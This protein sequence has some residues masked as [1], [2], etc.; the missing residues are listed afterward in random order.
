VKTAT[1]AR[2]TK[3]IEVDGR[4]LVISNEN[5]VLWPE[6]GYTKGDLIAYY[7][8]VARW[9][10]PHLENR[11]LTV[12]RYP[13][14]IHES[15]FFEKNAP[16]GLPDWIPTV[17]VPSDSGRR[18][19][20]HF[21]MCN[22]EPSLVYFGN[23]AAIV[24]HIWTSRAGSLEIPDFLFFDLDPGDGC[25]LATLAKVALELRATLGEIGLKP[26]IKTSGGSGLHVLVPLVPEYTYAI[27]KGFAEMI[28][29]TLNGRMPDE[30]TLARMPA[31][32]P[33]GTVYLDYVQVGMGKTLT[34]PY[35]VRARA[36]APVSFPLEW[37]EIES[38]SR[39]RAKDTEPE[40]AR[41]TIANV[42][43][44]LKKNGDLWAGAGWKEQR[45]EP[46]LAK[47]QKLWR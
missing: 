22:D 32:R 47:A 17:P 20:I 1:P 2:T 3:T 36:S 38:M 23:L 34:V 27:A 31:K 30:T 24:M 26:L 16:R 13:N 6:D 10:L 39:K 37:S 21:P 46:A 44:L 25:T 19:E 14:G 45:L 5:K 41:W 12:E 9:L 33:K 29:R 18:S 4:T 11:P 7:R 28:A 35:G 40:F 8:T 43:G 42:P 15:S